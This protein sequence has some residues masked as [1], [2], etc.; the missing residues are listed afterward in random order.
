MDCE[1]GWGGVIDRLEYLER[2]SDCG[3]EANVY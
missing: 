3:F 1:G 2:R